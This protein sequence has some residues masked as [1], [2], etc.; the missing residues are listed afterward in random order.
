MD[1]IDILPQ[2]SDLAEAHHVKSCELKTFEPTMK[3][4]IVPTCVHSAIF[5]HAI[6]QKDWIVSAA[7]YAI[8]PGF[9][10]D[11]VPGWQ[12]LLRIWRE[13]NTSLHPTRWKLEGQGTFLRRFSPHKELICII[14][15]GPCYP[16]CMPSLRKC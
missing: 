12:V 3:P 4:H 13:R 10:V 5:W 14:F 6:D 1:I 7:V 9:P 8:S 2:I 15:L 16:P 11:S